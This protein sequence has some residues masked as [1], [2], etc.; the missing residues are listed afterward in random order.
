MV[1]QVGGRQEGTAAAQGQVFLA[2]S[3]VGGPGVVQGK[4][5]VAPSQRHPFE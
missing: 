5:S 3:G 1:A 4:G 2:S